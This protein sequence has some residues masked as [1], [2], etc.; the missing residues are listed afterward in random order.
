M[1]TQRKDRAVLRLGMLR[2]EVGLGLQHLH[3]EV[4]QPH[5]P[6]CV[7]VVIEHR[8]PTAEVQSLAPDKA[9]SVVPRVVP[10]LLLRLAKSK[11]DKLHRRTRQEDAHRAV[12]PVFEQAR[13]GAD[14][15]E[16]QK[17]RV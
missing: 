4:P 11:T 13:P 10:A 17:T 9:Q 14:V 5:G 8:Q 3:K 16:A 12:L 6:V 2:V 1:L 7:R 15:Q